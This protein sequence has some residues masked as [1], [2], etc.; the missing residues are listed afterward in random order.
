MTTY[1]N[2][3]DWSDL[4]NISSTQRDTWEYMTQERKKYLKYFSGEVFTERVP[5]EA[6]TDTSEETPL[7]YPVGINLVKMLVLAQADALFGEWEEDIVRF[8][9]RQDEE[10]TKGAEEAIRLHSKILNDNSAPSL[11]YELAVD[12]EL[13]GGCATKVSPDLSMPGLIKYSR[14]DLNSFFPIWDP[15]DPDILLEVYAAVKMN[16]E[17]CRAKYGFDPGKDEV[18]R[19][20]HWTPRT[21][22]NR[23]DD[24]RIEAF[25]G[26]NPWGIVPFVYIPRMRTSS[27]YG[28]A[29]TPDVMP[30]QDELNM[31][32]ADTGDAIN[33]NAHP[34]RY[35]INMPRSF[36]SKNF[37]LGPEQFWDLG[38]VIGNSPSPEVGL[39]E[40]QNPVPEA[41]FK[42]IDFI[43]DWSRTAASTPPIAFGE[44]PGGGQRSGRTLEIRMWPLLRASRRSRGYMASGL[45][46]MMKM[47][48]V[49]LEQKKLENISQWAINRTRDGTVVPD[50]WPLMPKDQ[51]AIVDEVVKLFSTKPPN[52]SLETAQNILGRGPAEVE[53]IL[54]MIDDPK[55]KD[56]LM[57]VPALGTTPEG[58]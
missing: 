12:R 56:F 41:S 33:Y 38:K 45:I 35:G 4:G 24:K 54:E 28:D 37:P 13:Y 27:F 34:I 47:A 49:I 52:I 31:R 9:V 39:V 48:A 6:A 7:L 10:E 2:W 21:Y 18:W 26:V 5:P 58:E 3:P 19:I 44:D 11:F 20:E 32:V 25:S 51:A 16:R 50:F 43:Y 57:S 53:R 14:V 30:I 42:Y 40:A 22:E 46:R 29:I 8:R 23:I 55:L 36:N 15:D 17:Q 1:I